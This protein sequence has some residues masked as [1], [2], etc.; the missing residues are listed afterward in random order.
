M[1]PVDA[2]WA[3]PVDISPKVS[4]LRRRHRRRRVAVMSAVAV[5]APSKQ[6]L[7]ER[8]EALKPLLARNAAEAEE[9]R[10]I[11]EENIAAVKEAGGVKIKNP[12]RLGGHGGP[13]GTKPAGA[14]QRAA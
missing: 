13:V 10:R 5:D 11:P 2:D 12:P 4:T 1:R 9:T 3:E 6:E 14:A 8:A 7:V